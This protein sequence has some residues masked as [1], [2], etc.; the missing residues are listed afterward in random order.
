MQLFTR[1][2]KDCLTKIENFISFLQKTLNKV[3]PLLEIMPTIH[4]HHETKKKLDKLQ[5]YL[6]KKNNRHISHNEIVQD[7]VEKYGKV[8]AKKKK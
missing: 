3:S 8:Y 2:Y 5:D 7:F 4:L 1:L 6:K